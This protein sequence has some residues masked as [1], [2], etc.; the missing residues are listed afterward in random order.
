MADIIDGKAFA[1]G[2]RDKVT[3]LATRFENAAGRKA[4]PAPR[5]VSGSGP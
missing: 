4:G 2:L 3:T 1:E 5:S